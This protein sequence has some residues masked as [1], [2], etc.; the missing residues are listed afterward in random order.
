M[1][2]LDKALNSTIDD[3]LD[4]DDCTVNILESVPAA[5]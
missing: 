5:T 4:L 1:S 3:D 2:L